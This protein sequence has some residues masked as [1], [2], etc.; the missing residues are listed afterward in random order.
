MKWDRWGFRSYP[1]QSSNNLECVPWDTKL[2]NEAQV[3]LLANAPWE[4]GTKKPPGGGWAY[5]EFQKIPFIWWDSRL[6][7]SPK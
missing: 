6:F 4:M 3:R 7:G 2:A 1:K 5:Y